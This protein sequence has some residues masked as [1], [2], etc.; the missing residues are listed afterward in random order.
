[1]STTLVKGDKVTS[2]ETV[3]IPTG[4]LCLDRIDYVDGSSVFSSSHSYRATVITD[5]EIYT[6]DYATEQDARDA[7]NFH[8]YN[9]R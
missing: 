6:E 2:I 8:W 5:G 3:W 4:A 1:M 9:L 7:L